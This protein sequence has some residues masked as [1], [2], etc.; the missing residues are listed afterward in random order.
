MRSWLVSSRLVLRSFVP[1]DAAEPHAMLADPVSNTVGSGPFTATEQT[2]RWIRRRED[3]ERE[4]G[5][6]WY[7][8]RL[9]GTGELLGNC[10]M[11][12]GRT[13]HDEPEI[14]YLIRAD[15]RGQGYAGEAADAVLAECRATGLE[16]VWASI[17]P[18]NLASRRIV[19]GRGFRLDR[20]ERDE[21]GELLFYVLDLA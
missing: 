4:H 5:L 9:A 20:M 11:L 8:V 15:A 19:A 2:E 3:V 14:G 13:G 17:R 7:A 18:G 6:C 21:R 12:P 1:G 16:R 10:G